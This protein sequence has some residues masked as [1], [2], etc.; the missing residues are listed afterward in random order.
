MHPS[1]VTNLR[2]PTFSVVIPAYNSA[3]VITDALD[4]VFAQTFNDLEIVVVNDGSTDTTALE[5]V[6][7]PYHQRITY[8][9]QANK[10]PGGARNAGI[11]KSRGEFIAFLDSDDQWLPHHLSDMIEILRK[12]TTLDLVYA[13]AEN[14][15][16]PGSA[17]PSVMQRNPSEGLADFESL[18]LGRCTVVGSCMVARRQTLIDAGLF[19]ESLHQA[20]DFDLWARI[21]YHG[22]RIDY[23]KRIHTRRRVHDA[24]L[25]GDI[26]S[27][28]QWQVKVLRKLM[29]ELAIPGD[30]K[31]KMEREIERCEASI[32]LEKSKQL[33]LS[34]H[35]KEASEHLRHANTWYRS[36]KLYFV[37]TALTF[38]PPL[39]RQL[40]VNRSLQRGFSRPQSGPLRREI[41]GSNAAI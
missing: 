32:T 22:G 37:I 28:Y 30:L 40:L 23:I 14:F 7:A 24:N 29:S 34:R 5:S 9:S 12:D 31:H 35:Y 13:D 6:L 17:G 15:I 41:E 1:S 16:E 25:S 3:H 8:V 18:V 2:P 36:W 21:A 20:E 27:S 39:V 26:V 4:S 11:L 38:A 10:G 19:D 33:I